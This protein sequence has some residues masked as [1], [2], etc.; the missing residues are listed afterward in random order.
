MLSFLSETDK[1]NT[2]PWGTSCATSVKS[3]TKS[4]TRKQPSKTAFITAK[5]ITIGCWHSCITCNTN[6][7]TNTRPNDHFSHFDQW[8]YHIYDFYAQILFIQH[9][10]EHSLIRPQSPMIL[11]NVSLYFA[12]D[13]KCISKCWFLLFWVK[14]NWC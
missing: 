6:T 8:H 4:I 1:D 10:Y 5:Q 3:M 7:N 9:I 14:R 11:L 12:A 13:I 2:N